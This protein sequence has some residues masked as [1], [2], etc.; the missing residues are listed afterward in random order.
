MSAPSRIITALVGAAGLTLLVV[1]LGLPTFPFVTWFGVSLAAGSVVAAWFLSSAGPSVDAV[2]VPA[3]GD[4]VDASLPNAFGLQETTVGRSP[5]SHGETPQAWTA[6]AAAPDRYSPNASDPRDEDSPERTAEVSVIPTGV[7]PSDALEAFVRSARDCGDPVSAHL[8]LLDPATR[9]MRLV[10]AFGDMRP[11]AEP[12]PVEASAQGQAAEGGRAR[13]DAVR[14]IMTGVAWNPNATV[15]PTETTLWRYVVPLKAG[16]ASGAAVLEFACEEPDRVELNRAAGCARGALSAAL[17][18][19][20]SR[21][22]T[23]SGTALLVAAREILRLV[24]E[25]AILRQAVVHAARLSSAD[26]ASV[27]LLAPDTR[28]M[29]I[30]AASGLPEKVIRETRVSEGEGIAGWVLTTGNPLVVEDLEDKGPRSRRHGIRSAMA[31]PISDEEGILGVLNVGSRVFH[32]RFSA[33]QLANLESLGRVLALAL[34]NAAALESSR[35]LYL[36]TVRA[37]ALAIETKDPYSRGATD[38]VHDLASALGQAMGLSA[39]EHQA[40]RV[41]SMLHD[42]GMAAAGDLSAVA[43]R[44]LSTEEWAMLKMHPVIASDVLEQAHALKAAVPIVYHHHEHYDGQGYV[45]G[46]SGEQIPLGARVLSVADAYVAMTSPRPY[47]SAKGHREAVAELEDKAGTQFDPEVVRALVEM[48][49]DPE[50][51]HRHP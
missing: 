29:T 37:L 45:L 10:V 39:A 33:S 21:N 51:A 36:E 5:A 48:L 9:T 8:W 22:E 47:R 49:G 4:V 50:R 43:A 3:C 19:H 1:G 41:A 15:E 34:R 11:N 2:P 24:D 17:A 12:V 23:E 28:E 27:M 18:L 46:I 7:E 13:L 30:R 42:V 25:Q 20:V 14:R 31:V 35:D 26:T 6:P 32:A 16:E 38:R 40:L 44:P